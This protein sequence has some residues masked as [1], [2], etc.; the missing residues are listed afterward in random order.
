MKRTLQAVFL[1]VFA[2]QALVI[3]AWAACVLALSARQAQWLFL[4]SLNRSG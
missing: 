2:A 4:P 1:T 3:S